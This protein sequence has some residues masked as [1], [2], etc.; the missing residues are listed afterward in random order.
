MFA[1]K[2]LSGVR[3]FAF[4]ELSQLPYFIFAV[5]SRQT[6]L[7]LGCGDETDESDRKKK[8]GATLG[9]DSTQLFTLRQVHSARTV[10]LKPLQEGALGPADGV[11]VTEPGL[12]AAVRTADCMP[13]VAVYPQGKQVAL[14]ETAKAMLRGIG[15]LRGD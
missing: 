4:S 13:V 3:I 10:V 7:D 8:L 14:F 12:F 9:I 6:D 11:I 5:T 1:E 15:L 2:E